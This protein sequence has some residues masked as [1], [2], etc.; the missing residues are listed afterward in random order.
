MKNSDLTRFFKI[1]KQ[2]ARAFARRDAS[3]NLQTNAPVNDADTVNLKYFNEHSG[4]GGGGT[5]L[6]LLELNWSGDSYPTSSEAIAETFGVHSL[7]DYVGCNGIILK[8]TF[9]MDY[10]LLKDIKASFTD[11]AEITALAFYCPFM[12]IGYQLSYAD[13]VLAEGQFVQKI[14]D[15]ETVANHIKGGSQG[16]VLAKS[17]DGDY[18]FEWVDAGAKYLEISSYAEIPSSILSVNTYEGLTDDQDNPIAPFRTIIP[19]LSF[20]DVQTLL[21]DSSYTGIKWTQYQ[22]DAVGGTI[23]PS[24]TY[25]YLPILNRQSYAVAGVGSTGVSIQFYGVNIVYFPIDMEGVQ[26]VELYIQNDSIYLNGVYL[27]GQWQMS[28]RVNPALELHVGDV[29]ANGSVLQ[30]ETDPD[31]LTTQVLD[32]LWQ[33][34]EQSQTTIPLIASSNGNLLEINANGLVIKDGSTDV[35]MWDINNGWK[36]ESGA[37]VQTY[38]FAGLTNPEIITSVEYNADETQCELFIKYGL[39]RPKFIMPL[40]NSNS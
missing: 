8:N 21:S 35:V 7:S 3:G 30:F 34:Y 10:V 26:V 17:S 18:V 15:A 33:D 38:K 6:V 11:G 16:Q 2:G 37:T 25:A 9:G 13:G 39:F 22:R 31:V 12:D 36:V 1:D 32:G 24:G 20:S 28:E 29:I 14:K 19:N 5:G 27:E 4:G 40:L 23:T